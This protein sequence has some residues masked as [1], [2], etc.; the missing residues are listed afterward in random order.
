MYGISARSRCAMTSA[1]RSAKVTGQEY[2][3]RPGRGR[4]GPAKDELRHQPGNLLGRCVRMTATDAGLGERT[5]VAAHRVGDAKSL[6]GRDRPQ[7]LELRRRAAFEVSSDAIMAALYRARNALRRSWNSLPHTGRGRE[8]LYPSSQPLP[9][10][11]CVADTDGRAGSDAGARCLRRPR[12]GSAWQPPTVDRGGAVRR[13][14]LGPLS[15]QRFDAV[16]GG[17]GH[18]R[19]GLQV[20]RAR[21]AR[22]PASTRL[23]CCSSSQTAGHHRP[24]HLTG[25][26]PGWTAAP[27]ERPPRPRG[28]NARPRSTPKRAPNVSHRANGRWRRAS[29]SSTGGCAT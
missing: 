14:C 6:S 10:R 19:P 1:S 8:G 18:R 2:G 27:V 25:C 20:L 22:S 26:S 17:G 12:R 11:G 21:R 4:R 28:R 3:R 13:G 5:D 16:P 15:G 24:S 23:G 7:G 29:T 9:R